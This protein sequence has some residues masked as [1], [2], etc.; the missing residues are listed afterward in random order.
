MCSY[1]T[2]RKGCFIAFYSNTLSIQVGIISYLMHS[3]CC[4]YLFSY[5]FCIMITENLF[6]GDLGYELQ[7]WSVTVVVVSW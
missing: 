7:G 5:Y 4:I 3:V 2:E 6:K 1:N